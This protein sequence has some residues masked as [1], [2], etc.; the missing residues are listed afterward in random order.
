MKAKTSSC[1]KVVVLCSLLGGSLSV[2]HGFH[3]FIP[4]YDLL[5]GHQMGAKVVCGLLGV[6]RPTKILTQNRFIQFE[7]I[8]GS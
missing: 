4:K 2:W 3:G 7:V 6:Y 8:I 1:L 5:C